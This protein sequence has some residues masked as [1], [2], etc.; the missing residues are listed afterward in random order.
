MVATK[1]RGAYQGDI[2]RVKIQFD[3]TCWQENR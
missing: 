3:G 2:S 1:K